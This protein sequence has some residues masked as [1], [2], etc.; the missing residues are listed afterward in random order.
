MAIGKHIFRGTVEVPNA[1]TDKEAINYGQAKALVNRYMKEPVKVA[2]TAELNGTYL[3]GVYTLNTDIH[4]I[5]GTTLDVDDSILVKDEINKEY[6]GV[7]VITDLGTASTPSSATGSTTSA[8]ITKVTVDKAIFEAKTGANTDKSYVFTYDGTTDMTWKDDTTT[9][10]TL[11]D[12]GISIEGTETDAD[13]IT[14]AYVAK[15]NGTGGI[16]TRRDDFA[17]GKIILNNTFVNVME[18]Q[19]NGDTR[20]TIVSNGVLTVG[21]SEFIFVKDIDTE[22]SNI[23]VAK[24]TVTP[25]GVNKVFNISHNFHLQDE[26]GYILKILDNA[27]NEVYVDNTPKLGNENDAITLTFESIPEVTETFKVYIL[28]LE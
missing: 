28:G 5:D 6:N 26:Y 12:Y 16:I 24:V 27:H 11:A 20:W 14:V 3:D 17:E 22:Q 9:S 8:T 19:D 15:V 13:T 23:K 1:K 4:E 25:D 18:G 21:T 10:V 7:Y 2:T